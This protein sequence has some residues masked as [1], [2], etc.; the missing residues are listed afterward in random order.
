MLTEKLTK[1]KVYILRVGEGEHLTGK[2]DI[3]QVKGAPKEPV[4]VSN[5]G[6]RKRKDLGQSFKWV[7]FIAE[8]V[9]SFVFL[10]QNM[11]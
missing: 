9:L 7:L 11:F 2:I 4:A 1:T 10:I 6:K 3:F 8:C 5:S